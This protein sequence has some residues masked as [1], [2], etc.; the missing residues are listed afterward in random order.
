MCS[1]SDSGAQS[2]TQV[3]YTQ[4]LPILRDGLGQ[5]GNLEVPHIPTSDDIGQRFR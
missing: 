1:I 4:V 2:G 3:Q 5:A